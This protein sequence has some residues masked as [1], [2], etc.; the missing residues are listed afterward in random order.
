MGGVQKINLDQLLDHLKDHKLY[1]FGIQVISFGTY[2][3]VHYVN[4]FAKLRAR[5]L[6]RELASYALQRVRAKKIKN[7]SILAFDP[8]KPLLTFISERRHIFEMNARIAEN[9]Q[10][11]I[12]GLML[13][14][15]NKAA[16]QLTGPLFT[17]NQIIKALSFSFGGRYTEVFKGAMKKIR[18]FFE[19]H[20]L[21]VLRMP[22]V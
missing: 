15:G 14:H 8:D 1:G 19:G 3:T 11:E 6:F 5:E 20:E 9:L 22:G 12:Q 13:Y 21:S 10:G 16:L 4:R 7:S 2:L 18:S 17:K